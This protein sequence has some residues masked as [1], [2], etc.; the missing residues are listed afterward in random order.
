MGKNKITRWIDLQNEKLCLKINTMYFKKIE[1]GHSIYYILTPKFYPFLILRF[2]VVICNLFR[3]NPLLFEPYG[4]AFNHSPFFKRVF[5]IFFTFCGLRYFTKPIYEPN[6]YLDQF[7]GRDLHFTEVENPVVSII[8]PVYNQIQY[9]KT[10]LRSLILNVSTQYSYEVILIDDC[11]TDETT[12]TLETISGLKY[13]RNTVNLGF[14]HSCR[15]GIEL[16]KGNYI[17]LLNNDT[18][19][20]PNWLESLVDTIKEDENV[21]C[22]GSKLIYPYGLLQ[23][24]G[25]IIYQDGSGANYGKYQNPNYSKYNYKRV[26][27]YSSGASILFGRKDYDLVGGLD[28]RYEPAYYEDTDFCFAIRHILGKNVVYQPSSVVVHFEGVSSGKKAEKG[29]VKSYQDINKLKFIEKWKSYLDKNYPLIKQDLA[30]KKYL[31]KKTIIVIDSYLPL[32]DRESGSNRLYQLLLIFKTMGYHLLFVPNN[33]KIVEPY[34]SILTSKLGIEV[35]LKE[36]GKRS[37]KNK[38]IAAVKHANILWICRPELNKKFKYLTPFNSNIKWIYDTVDLHYVR[39]LREC[40][41]F[42]KNLKFKYKIRRLKALELSLAKQADCTIAI[43]T[44]EAETLKREGVKNV[45]VIPNI[46]L[47]FNQKTPEFDERKDLCFIGSYKHKPNI[48]AAFWLIEDIMP[49]VW[50]KRPEIKV[51]LLGNNP[52]PEILSLQNDRI[53]VPGFIEDVSSYFLD[54][55]VF[56]APL[57]YG[58]GMKGKI[59]QSLSFGLPIVSTSIGTEGMHLQDGIN[60]LEANDTDEFANKIIQLYEDQELWNKIRDNANQTLSDYTP[61]IVLKKLELLFN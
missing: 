12:E 56:V 19:L 45:E 23:E 35:L 46:H 55:K 53:I 11:S 49:I 4:R 48:D 17:C 7:K 57:R 13:I 18:I 59:G 3:F 32:F 27:D 47:P 20:L 52:T 10:C 2:F 41:L 5:E 43:T 34:Y 44:I 39:L 16:S 36:R 21:G 24:A 54:S 60:V 22:V 50:G 25:G 33:G 15:K 9:T 37:L 31:P 29:N 28:T 42:S 58:A 26:V 40:N 1:R 51:Y 30:A 61:E 8:I 38:L 6:Y 14:L